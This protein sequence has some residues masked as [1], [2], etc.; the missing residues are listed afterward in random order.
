MFSRYPAIHAVGQSIKTQ[1]MDM[2]FPASKI[3]VIP[4]GFPDPPTEA[5]R[6]SKE[7]LMRYLSLQ[8]E[9]QLVL[10]VGNICFRK[11]SH[12]ILLLAQRIQKLHPDVH[13]LIVGSKDSPLE[14]AYAS[15][16][17]EWREKHHINNFHLLGYVGNEVLDSLFHHSDVYLSS[18]LSEACN[19]SLM[20]AAVQGLPIVSTDVGAGRDLFEPEGTIIPRNCSVKDLENAITDSL[21]V[22]RNITYSKIKSNSW[23]EVAQRVVEYYDFIIE[24]GVGT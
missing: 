6:L 3:R 19:L 8:L 9:S 22:N 23:P 20:E 10:T 7:K 13:F 17:L 2:G 21:G 24:S 1:L 12:K 5:V 14:Q 16:L 11:A 18:S 15:R 4:N